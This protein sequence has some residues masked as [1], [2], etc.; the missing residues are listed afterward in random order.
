MP[1]IGMTRRE[2]VQ[3][4]THRLVMGEL[5]KGGPKIEKTS[6]NGKKYTTFGP[7]LDYWRFTSERQEV[8]AAWNTAVM[9]RP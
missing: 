7:D 2:D 3:D 9:D 4:A 5:N 8:L 6:P 1:I